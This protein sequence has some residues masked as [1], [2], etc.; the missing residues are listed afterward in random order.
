[1]DFLKTCTTNIHVV[2]DL[3][4]TAL[5]LYRLRDERA[6][7]TQKLK[8]A[9]N[10]VSHLRREKVLCAIVEQDIYIFGDVSPEHTLELE[11]RYELVEEGTVGSQDETTSV[12][13]KDIFLDA[14]EHAIAFS[15]AA[16]S[17]ITYVASWTWLYHDA[18]AENGSD[19]DSGSIIKM[20]AEYTP[21]AALLL[22]PEILPA[23]WLPIGHADEQVE[24]H[25]ILAP[26]GI[27]AR[28]IAEA[29]RK[30]WSDNAWKV[31]VS[32]ALELDAIRTDNDTVWISVELQDSAGLCCL[33]PAELC[34]APATATNL[35][36]C[37]MTRRS[38]WRR[39]LVGLE[40]EDAFR[41]PLAV[42]EE[43][44]KGAGER[45]QA[46]QN[47]VKASTSDPHSSQ[48]HVSTAA[49]DEEAMTS[50]PFMQRAL[51]Q[52]TAVS[53]IYPTPPDGMAQAPQTAHMNLGATPSVAHTDNTM[54]GVEMTSNTNDHAQ[55]NGSDPDQS[56]DREDFELNQEDLF[57]DN[58]GGIEF[59][60]DA[61]D[62]ADFNFFDEPDDEPEQGTVA[63]TEMDDES[64]HEHELEPVIAQD[65]VNELQPTSDDISTAAAVDSAVSEHLTL[66]T[67]DDTAGENV[68]TAGSDES[69]FATH[70]SEPEK[71]L[72]PFGIRER[73]LPPP[74]PAS[75]AN[76]DSNDFA[77]FRRH[78]TFAPIVFKNSFNLGPK[79]ADTGLVDD[80]AQR[81]MI[82]SKI[83]NINLPPVK[84]KSRLLRQE[85]NMEPRMM[86]PNS[87]SEE[88]SYESASSDSDDELPPKLPWDTR[89][90]KRP[91]DED[92][93]QPLASSMERMLSDDDPGDDSETTESQHNADTM[94][95]KCLTRA[96]DGGMAVSLRNSSDNYS[97]CGPKNAS[98][99]ESGDS[100]MRKVEELYSLRKED[101]IYVAQI[102]HEQAMS[103]T[104]SSVA[105]QDLFSN[106]G[107][108]PEKAQCG[109]ISIAKAVESVFP[110]AAICDLVQLAATRDQ[111]PRPTVPVK[112]PQG[113][114]RMP[115]RS[116][117]QIVL[118]PDYFPLPSP[119]VRI[120]RG[121]DNWEMMSTCLSFWE[122]LGLGPTNGPKN[123]RAFCVFPFNE[124]LQHLVA[125][126]I[127]ELG[128][129]Y[130]NCKL[131]SYVHLRN[132]S[133]ASLDSFEDGMAPVEVNEEEESVEGLLKAYATTCAELGKVLSTIGHEE[134]DRTIVVYMLNPFSGRQALQH[135]CACFWVLFKAYR[136]NVPKALRNQCGSDI[137]LQ[138][139]P[140]KLVASFDELVVPEAKEIALLAREVYDRCPPSVSH[141]SETLSA[142][143]I[144][145]A[146][147][148]ELANA[149]PKRIGFQLAAEPPSD[150]LHEGSILHLAYACSQDGHWLTVAWID[151]TGQHQSTASFCLRGKTFSE[152][153]EGVW[154]RT[155]EI[156]AARQV[157]WRV[158]IVTPDAMDTSLS[159]CW[160]SITS[161]R[162]PYP[163]CVTLLSVQLDPILHL[164]PP[165]VPLD[166]QFTW[167]TADGG[168]L[169]PAS[170][171]QAGNLTSSPNPGGDSTA[172]PTPAPSETMTAASIAENDPDA[173]LTDLTDETWG[174]LL[175]PKLAP[176]TS[177]FPG[178]ANGALFRRG[179]PS[180]GEALP[181]LGV[182]VHWTIQVKPSGGVDDGSVKQAEL[183]CRE[184]LKMYRGLS[185]LT[186]ARGLDGG[187]RG[188]EWV[189]P[190]HVAM[191]VR[192]VEG[193][194][195]FLE[196]DE[197]G[198][199]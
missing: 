8:E 155:R 194:E 156:L 10:A 186:K 24:S 111:A 113:Q 145:A 13:T 25:I 141:N 21:T 170:T 64:T 189:A 4:E 99:E 68:L 175:S 19:A 9:R 65:T 78:S 56:L 110:D 106:G 114:P 58:S 33:W 105:E 11:D 69:R 97:D 176:F 70:T 107:S 38:D 112:T 45:E 91:S 183:T 54:S 151:N 184:V 140:I 121:A 40:E 72:S 162:R 49:N 165:A 41:N 146:P 67:S 197:K 100:S 53:G 139:L 168:F 80:E 84:K 7:S 159:H 173:H 103:M 22:V 92:R 46:V 116:D 104:R 190:V 3:A 76:T 147:S 166:T 161:R 86:D 14:V 34:L 138:V 96:S 63:S 94:L 81:P 39:W 126:F 37:A 95:E 93:L 132:V 125:Q 171:P 75:L 87:E 51:D 73:L 118:G 152:V 27:P 31:N 193:L 16:D 15:L 77:R 6:G 149:A 122:T 47:A 30:V 59:G 89:K 144:L 102:V 66:P 44:F 26:R 115:Q 130:E 29:R 150:L 48:T 167:P 120:Q 136:D 32:E 17:A 181:S 85:V 108:D 88:D 148:V 12:N 60:E 82:K 135:L 174:V 79:Y 179:D 119:Y 83:P 180:P 28:R 2:E 1:M 178:Q 163:L 137:V 188:T 128:T 35:E 169:T 131:G 153:A 5:L 43:W 18:E 157:T 142:L 57:G 185:V 195:G 71:A 198:E 55:S 160:R 23:S 109:R 117:S 158:F 101:L 164:S 143:P 182:S 61:V 98:D 42:A 196:K 36:F 127:G 129:S 90:R 177:P 74:V 172:P 124:D 187:R 192:G 154:D 123:V 133:D 52:Q 191:V 62:D 20:H 50:P 134:S 199:S